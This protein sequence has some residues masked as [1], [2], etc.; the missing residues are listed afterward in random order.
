MCRR[1]TRSATR[2]SDYS[3]KLLKELGREEALRRELARSLL[4]LPLE[5][6]EPVMTIVGGKI[7]F[8]TGYLEGILVRAGGR[9]HDDGE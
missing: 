5:E 1:Q 6:L 2:P 9:G 8:E 4:K 3:T 7:V